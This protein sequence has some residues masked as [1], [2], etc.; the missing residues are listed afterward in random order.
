MTR[1]ADNISLLSPTEVYVLSRSP[2][3]SPELILLDVLCPMAL[4]YSPGYRVRPRNV[5]RLTF[6]SGQ[7]TKKI[8]PYSLSCDSSFTHQEIVYH[9][10]S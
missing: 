5:G 1:P 3:K 6:D 8:H 7:L 4:L 10:L 2:A 9:P